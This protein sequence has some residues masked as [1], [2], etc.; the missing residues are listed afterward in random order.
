MFTGNSREVVSNQEGIHEHLDTVVTKHL[1][2]EFQKPYAAHTVAAFEQVNQLV[3]AHSGRIIL[4]S[5]CGVGESTQYIAQRHP[6]ALVVGIDKSLSRINRHDGD[7]TAEKN[8]VLVRADLNDFWRLALEAG[9]V[10]DIHFL[11]YPNPWPKSKHLQR[12]WHGAPIFSTILQL[13]GQLFVRSNWQTYIDEFHRA[14]EIAGIESH[15]AQYI[16]DEP[17]TPF[18]RKYL[19]SGHQTWQVSCQLCQG[20]D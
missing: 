3:Q 18:E 9:W 5:C 4:D 12:R 17:M 1:K 16:V 7:V 15:K 10:I 13:G 19:Q 2:T 14:L 11:L 8:Y 20:S 6:D